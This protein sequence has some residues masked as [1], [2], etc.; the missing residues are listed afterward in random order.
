M[1]RFEQKYWLISF[2]KLN[3]S[4]AN[5]AGLWSAAKKAPARFLQ[6]SLLRAPGERTGEAAGR[7]GAAYRGHQSAFTFQMY[8]K[9]GKNGW[10][11]QKIPKLVDFDGGLLAKSLQ[12]RHW[13]TETM[14]MSAICVWV[15]SHNVVRI[16]SSLMC[17]R[18]NVE[19][20]VDIMN[21]LKS[22]RILQLYEAYDNGRNEMCLM[23]E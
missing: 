4:G 1:N 22:P 6:Q 23:T 18:R 19:R 12:K 11:W 10:K 7:C 21:C 17:C 15:G 3:V 14:L 5:L 20:E 9:I 13:R 8:L 16:S 2:S